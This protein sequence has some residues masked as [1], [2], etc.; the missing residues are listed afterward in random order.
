M[1][2]VYNNRVLP[3]DLLTETIRWLIIFRNERQQRLES[4]IQALNTTRD[5]TLLLSC[6]DIVNL[7]EKHLSLKGTSRLPVLIVA[8]AYKVA[9]N[10]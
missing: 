10:T 3:F 7:I 1:D 2:D 8:A 6:E 4:L 9:E 5:D